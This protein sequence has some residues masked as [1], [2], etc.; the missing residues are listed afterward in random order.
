MDLHDDISQEEFE[1]IEAYLN[2]S[3][4]DEDLSAFEDRLQNEAGFT[5]KVEDI[6]AILMGLE[7]QALKEQLDSF[8]KDLSNTEPDHLAQPRKVRTLV[9]RR[10]A[11][12]AVII[13]ATGSFWFLS[14]NANDQLYADYY[15]PDPGLPTT[16]GDTENYEFYKA[17]V[18]YKQGKYDDALVVWKG[19]LKNKVSS[20]TLSYFIGSALLAN[21]KETEAISYLTYVTKQ[22]GTSFKD[23][24]YFY[25]GLAYL[26]AKKTEDAKNALS[27]SDLKEAKDLL[28]KL[29]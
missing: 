1:S 22:E 29:D 2:Q 17:M 18:S 19:Q 14:G 24:A 23:D 9:W 15:K 20:D 4:S 16:M 26:K 7:T 3:L 6:K 11:V 8:H 5:T 12:A 25:L 13:I 28:K 10:I 21:K 27:Q